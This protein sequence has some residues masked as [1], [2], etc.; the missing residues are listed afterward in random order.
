MK[1]LENKLKDELETAQV[2][3]KHLLEE[4]KSVQRLLE[5]QREQNEILAALEHDL[6]K[7]YDKNSALAVEIGRP[8][9]LHRWR[10]LRDK[11]PKEFM[12]LEKI[13]NLQRQAIEATSRIT[14]HTSSLEKKKNI[15]SKLRKDISGQESVDD[16]SQGLMRLKSEFHALNKEIKSQETELQKRI[17]KA[18]EF[19][20]EIL[21]LEKIRMEM[22][23]DY[24][25]SV[26]GGR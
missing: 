3:T 8:I 18:K 24:I 19:N 12:M 7:Q 2:K 17:N 14:T 5:K 22:K 16:M 21:K 11:A 23:A 10:Y 13:Q 6:S 20:L 25:V 15:L 9:N 1:E 4:R 26:I